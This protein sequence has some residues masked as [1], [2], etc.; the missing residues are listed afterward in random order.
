MT[1][2]QNGKIYKI[3]CVNGEDRDI[4]IGSTAKQYLSQRMEKHRTSYKLWKEGKSSYVSAY[5]L[6]DKFGVE[7]C[8][9][10]LIEVC[11]CDLKD[12][13]RAREGF[14]IKNVEC[15]NK[16]IENRTQKEWRED[17]KEIIKQKK[18]DYHLNNR[19]KLNEI[20][21]DY[22]NNHLEEI[23]IK[24]H[25]YYEA[26]KEYVTERNKKYVEENTEKNKAYKQQ[27]Y[28]DNKDMLKEKNKKYREDNAEAIKELRKQ[29]YS[30]NRDVL[31]EKRKKYREDNAE[32]I[33]VYMKQWRLNKK[34]EKC[35]V[36]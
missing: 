19:E 26:N 7:N 18:H 3:E 6:F 10:L 25:N 14:H 12:E 32:S 5:D 36:I 31:N 17:N 4:Y 27:Y 21:K 29:T 20:S 33:K 1:N 9:I 22:R 23:K 15:V 34:N 13:L 35:P 28:C 16:R 30:D 24:Q 8:S 11:P 2:Y